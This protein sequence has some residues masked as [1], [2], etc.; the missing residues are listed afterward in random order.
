MGEG[1]G[2]VILEELNHVQE[3]ER[4]HAELIGYGAAGDGYHIVQPDPEGRGAAQAFSCIE[5]CGE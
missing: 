2:I 5:K 4:D 1:A 3:R